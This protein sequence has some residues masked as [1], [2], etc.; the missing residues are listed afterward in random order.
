LLCAIGAVSIGSLAA[1]AEPVLAEITVTAQKRVQNLQDTP[2]SIAAFG[3]EEIERRGIAKLSDLAPSVP[4]LRII[5]FGVSPTTL[6]V[7]IRGVGVVDSQVTQDPPVGIYMNGVYIARPVGLS[8]D[9]PDIERIEVLR[10]P[11]GTLYGRNTTG[12]AVNIITTKPNDKFGFSQL[13]SAGNYDSI[14]SQT[15]VNLPII[16]GLFARASFTLNKRDGWLKNTGQGRDF[17]ERDAKAGRVDLRWKPNEVFTMD[18]DYDHSVNDYTADYY[19]LIK[20][21]PPGAFVPGL[22]E[23]P[24]RLDNAS[25]LAPFG[26]S[27]DKAIGHTLT[28]SVRTHVGEFKSISAYRKVESFSYQ[29]F[30]ANPFA[31]IYQNNPFTL[32]QDQTSQEFQLVGSNDAKS[33]D[34]VTGVY[35]FKENAREI[36][37]DVAFAA[38][39]IP[40]DIDAK[41]KSYAAYGQGTWHPGS[42]PWGFTVG[43]R[44][45]KDERQGDNHAISPVSRQDSNFSPSLM[46][47]YRLNDNTLLYGKAVQGYKAGGFNM[48]QAAAEFG[49]SF[50][51]EKLLTYELGVKSESLGR[52]LRLNTALFYSDYKDIQLDILVPDQPNPTLTRTT[53]AG[54][55]RV[56]GVESE[57]DF[58]ATE[59]L[60]LA[61][62]FGYL[63]AKIQ[64]IK[65][66]D[67]ALWRLPNAPKTSWTGTIDWDLAHVWA[68]AVNLTVD[69]SWRA[70]S[71]TASRKRPGDDVMSY[72]LTDARLSFTREKWFGEETKTRVSIWVKNAFDKQYYLDTFG[73]FIGLHAT[74]VATFGLP[75]TYGVEVKFDY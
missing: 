4:N 29:D 20:A 30:S 73:S 65:G 32:H 49:N 75:R 48:R 12:G 71:F 40:R 17:S 22:P 3:A 54:K 55:A 59:N 44:Y 45:T 6:R 34:Y 60:R 64:E 14:K 69:S 10:G 37:R 58:A 9:I 57:A 27:N 47:D 25:L 74:Q 31:T 42:G 15:S 26:R 19:H 53:N 33:F 35:Y 50:G 28:V 8:L 56:I 13:V 67:P 24:N 61:L 7:Y 72:G 11:Q 66:D 41:N 1:A 52:R 2:I 62:A 63:D 51:P 46:A 21:A 43:G 5:P 36:A 39:P 18:Y 16:D 38:F 68:G 23:Q 70:E